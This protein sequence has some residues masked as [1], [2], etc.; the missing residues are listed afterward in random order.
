MAKV[1]SINFVLEKLRS[2]Y[3]IYVINVS[4]LQNI[5]KCWHKTLW[6]GTD[7]ATQLKSRT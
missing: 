1:L 7:V 2:F 3:N 4:D 6:M 5:A